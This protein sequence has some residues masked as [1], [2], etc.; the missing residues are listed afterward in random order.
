MKEH[1]AREY[2]FEKKVNK[3]YSIFERENNNVSMKPNKISDLINIDE[4]T[5]FLNIYRK[6]ITKSSRQ[7]YQYQ[8][9][10]H[11]PSRQKF[12]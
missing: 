9:N 3:F 5:L 10:F 1:Q 8:H 6:I 7:K 4:R 12:S 2:I 11:Y